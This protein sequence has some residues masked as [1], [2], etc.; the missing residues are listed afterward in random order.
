MKKGSY[1]TFAI[2]LTNILIFFIILNLIC[3]GI[4]SIRNA[5]SGP[6]KYSI[7]M[8]RQVYPGLS[9]K[10]IHIL[11]EETWEKHAFIYKPYVQ[12]KDAPLT[13]KF[14]NIDEEGFREVE[15]QCDYPIS[16]NNYNIFVFGGSSVL[17][18]GVADWE[19][20][21]SKIQKILS[22]EHSNI[23][24]Y[25]F[26]SVGHFSTQERIFFETLLMKEQIP[27]MVIFIDGIND[28]YF[29]DDPLL[30]R[31]IDEYISYG[32]QPKIMIKNLPLVRA[33]NYLLRKIKSQEGPEYEQVINHMIMRLD[34][35]Q[36]I[37]KALAQEYG[38]KYY[39]VIQPNPVYNYNLKYHAIAKGELSSYRRYYPYFF[40]YADLSTHYDLL[41]KKQ[42]EQIIWLADMQLNKTE[43][44]YVDLIHYNAKFSEEIAQEISNRIKKDID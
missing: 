32:K 35:N 24:V 40:G 16:K 27:N 21:P 11:T 10:D 13:G 26:A 22:Q 25:N 5:R 28:F 43:N 12:F 36:K 17:G 7:E 19:T 9:D 4:I 18:Y 37:I 20:I 23:C 14:V 30:T 2:I 44:L 38:V 29:P 8:L 41:D 3:Y 33:I 15:N 1:K 42:D 39:F 34:N 6:R 31:P